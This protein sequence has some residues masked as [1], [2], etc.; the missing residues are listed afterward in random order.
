MCE[1]I[2]KIV[3]DDDLEKFFQVRAPLLPQE[4]EK[5]IVFFKR[6]IDVFAWNSYKVP[7]WIQT[8]FAII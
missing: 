8:S 5:L 7:R 3:I 1:E 4:K 2:E 6:N